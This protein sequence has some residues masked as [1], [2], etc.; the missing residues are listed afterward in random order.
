MIRTTL[1]GAALLASLP[2]F[3]QDQPEPK[4]RPA[5]ANSY[6]YVEIT[7]RLYVPDDEIQWGPEPFDYLPGIGGTASVQFLPYAFAFIEAEGY[8]REEGEAKI[9]SA[10]LSG[11]VGAVYPVVDQLD[12][13]ATVAYFGETQEQCRLSAC[14]EGD[15]DG[16]A[17]G[18]GFRFKAN[19]HFDI[20]AKYEHGF[21]DIEGV[22]GST[23]EDDAGRTK[24]ELHLSENAHGVI[25]GADV[26]EE[27]V[28]FKLGYRYTFN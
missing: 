10:S 17:V 11:G 4:E 3:A 13:L 20:L 12:M 15:A 27:S 14:L 23:S 2:V 28:Y 8:R 22:D 21:F 5:T 18:G 6:S 26:M 1:L 24:V 19:E 25:A 9:E 16:Y 7:G